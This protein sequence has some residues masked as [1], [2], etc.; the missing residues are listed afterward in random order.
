MK[1][2]YTL[3]L[4]LLM[5]A[6]F[7]S[8]QGLAHSWWSVRGGVNFSNLS[9]PDYSTRYLTGYSVGVAYAQPISRLAPIYLEGGVYYQLKGA[10]DNGFLTDSSGDSQLRSYEL[11]V[12]L[13]VGYHAAISNEW[14][15]QSVVG[16]YYSVAL[17]GEFR[18]G[19]SEFNPYKEEMLQTLRDSSPTMQQLL[20]RSDFGIRVGFTVLY[21]D[22]TLGFLFDGG[23]LNRYT[24]SLRDAGYLA[25]T[26]CFTIQAGY[27]F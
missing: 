26:G 21:G 17:N 5:S 9:S 22:Y 7:V 19:D 23:L 13:L 16:L 8:A 10:R 24:S 2:I 25:R 4:A 11:E 3:L 27:N 20:N 18:I 6:S 15:I 1:K 14:S 12:P